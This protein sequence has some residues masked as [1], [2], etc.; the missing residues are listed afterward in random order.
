MS[1]LKVKWVFGFPGDLQA[2]S[3]P[4]LAAGRVFTGSQAGKVYALDAQ[5][6]CIVWFFDA[7]E[8]GAE[9]GEHW[10]HSKWRARDRYAAFFGDG[11]ATFTR[12]DAGTWKAAVEDEG[13]PVSGGSHDRV[14]CVSQRQAVCA[15]RLGRRSCGSVARL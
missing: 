7:L 11:S 10:T 1:R 14:A 13:R 12:L 9:R 5:T 15:R 6:G 3:Q 4:T 8:L 2:Y